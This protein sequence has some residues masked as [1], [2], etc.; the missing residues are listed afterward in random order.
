VGESEDLDLRDPGS[1]ESI[2]N[3]GI[4]LYNLMNISSG[5][6]LIARE[7]VE[8]FPETRVSAVRLREL[9]D[10]GAD[11]NDA[12]VQTFLELLATRPDTFV[13]VKFGRNISESVVSEAGWIVLG[14]HQ[15]GFARNLG[16]IE[17]FDRKL[18]TTRVNPGSTADIIIAALFIALLGG[19]RP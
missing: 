19:L 15:S 16:K 8:G 13:Q 18:I 1:I 7:W 14:I 9:Y 11:L 4:T 6:D 17:A 3:R 5:Y 10:S 2:K 12:I